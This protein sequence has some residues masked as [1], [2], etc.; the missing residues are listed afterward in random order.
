MTS[1]AL[2]DGLLKLLA[3]DADDLG[4]NANIAHARTILARGT[5][6]DRQ[7]A[8]YRQQ[9]DQGVTRP[10]ALRRIV[11]QLLAETVHGI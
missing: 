11:D 3:E 9:L 10:R 8:L 4:A 2:V 7:L 1:S 6:A 5:S